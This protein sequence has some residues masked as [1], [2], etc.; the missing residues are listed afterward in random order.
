MG[1]ELLAAVMWIFLTSTLVSAKVGLTHFVDNQP[2]LKAIIKG[3]S[4]QPDLN[5]IIGGLWYEAGSRLQNYW[6]T[7]VP[8]KSNLADAHS[9]QYVHLM[10]QLHA[11]RVEF[12][13]DTLVTVV[14]SWITLPAR[15]AL[16]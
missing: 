8:S 5:G 3:S 11:R 2:A 16:V 4:K 12:D 6:G 7:Y 14:E 1:Y 10:K 13:F 9:R 15:M